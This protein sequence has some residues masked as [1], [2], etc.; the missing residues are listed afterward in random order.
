MVSLPGYQLTQTYT[1]DRTSLLARGVRLTD[2]TPV[3]IRLLTASPP[4]YLELAHL[5]RE[6]EIT[7]KLG[8]EGVLEPLELVR[9]EGCAALVTAD[10]SGEVCDLET[11]LPRFGMKRLITLAISVTDIL[12][13]LHHRGII[14]Q[15]IRPSSI[16]VDTERFEA[17]LTAFRVAACPDALLTEEDLTRFHEALPYLSPEQTGRASLQVTHYSD[18]YSLGMTLYALASGTPPFAYTDPLELVHAHMA[19]HPEPLDQ[20]TEGPALF[21]RIIDKLM[22]KI[23]EDRYHGGAG[24]RAD[25]ERCLAAGP[26]AGDT[27]LGHTDISQSFHI[28]EKLYGRDPETEILTSVWDRARHGGRCFLPVVGASGMGKS[29]LVESLRR[30]V[31]AVRGYFVR[32]NCDHRRGTIPYDALAGAMSDL[33]HQLMAESS[34]EIARRRAHLDLS[35]GDCGRVM[36]DMVPALRTILGDREEPPHLDPVEAE[37]RF[38]LIFRRFVSVFADREH[39]LVIYLT[40]LQWTGSST[41]ELLDDLLSDSAIDH[42]LIVGSMTEHPTDPSS[43]LATTMAHWAEVGIMPASLEVPAMDRLVIQELLLDALGMPPEDSKALA[44]LVLSRTG[45]VPFD[46]RMM[47]QSMADEEALIFDAKLGRWCWKP[48]RETGA[49]DDQPIRHL[50]NKILE[51]SQDARGVL[52]LASCIGN[53]FTL[54]MLSIALQRPRAETAERL[55]EAVDG[56]LVVPVGDAWRLLQVYDPAELEAVEQRGLEINYRFSHDRVHQ[57]VYE[58]MAPS[59]SREQHMTVGRRFLEHS[60][61]HALSDQIFSIVSQLNQGAELLESDEERAQL[62]ELNR[63]AGDKARNAAAFPDAAE[64]YRKGIALLPRESIGGHL[65]LS[66]HL[67]LAE[68]AILNGCEEEAG[69]QIE[70]LMAGTSRVEDKLRVYRQRVA[71]LHHAGRLREAVSRGLEALRLVDIRVPDTREAM[72]AEAERSRASLE[73][74]LGTDPGAALDATVKACEEGDRVLQSLLLELLPPV[75]NN[76]PELFRLLTSI[77]MDRVLARGRTTASPF[78]VALFGIVSVLDGNSV[79]GVALGELAERMSRSLPDAVIR[80]RL[81]FVTCNVLQPWLRDLEANIPVM[82]RVFTSADESG[83]LVYA[84]YAAVAMSHQQWAREKPL[85]EVLDQCEQNIDYLK[86]TRN[87]VMS[88]TLSHLSRAILNLRGLSLEA[89]SLDT[90]DFDTAALEERLR[91]AGYLT[92]LALCRTVR[93]QVLFLRG[94]TGTAHALAR[95]SLA[96]MAFTEGLPTRPLFSL[97]RAL[98]AAAVGGN[99]GLAICEEEE[100]RFAKWAADC[101]ES[102]SHRHALVRAEIARLQGRGFEAQRHYH[103]AV[104][105]AHQHAYPLTEAT[106]NM[107]ATKFFFERSFPE[108]GHTHLDGAFFCFERWGAVAVCRDL[109]HRYTVTANDILRDRYRRGEDSAAGLTNHYAQALDRSTLYKAAQALTGEIRL[110]SLLRKMMRFVSENAGAQRGLFLMDH[111]G[112]MTVEVEWRVFEEESIQSGPCAMSTRDD[113]AKPVVHYVHRTRADLLIDNVARDKR[114]LGDPYLSDSGVKTVLCVPIIRQ[115]EL[116]GI[117]YLENHLLPGAFTPDRLELLRMLAPQIAVSIENARFIESMATL[118]ATLEKEIAERKRA[119]NDLARA[120]QIAL[121]NARNVGKAEF[122]TSVLHNINNVLNS[123]SLACHEMQEIIEDSVTTKLTRASALMKEHEADL[124]SFLTEHERGKLI[125]GYLIGVSEILAQERDQMNG[126]LESMARNLG[127]MKGIIKTQQE[128]AKGALCSETLDPVVLFEEALALQ[129]NQI[130]RHGI[131]V[132]RRFDCNEPVSARRAELVHIL[133][134]LIK[135]AIEAMGMQDRR[136]LHLATDREGDKVA[137]HVTDSGVGIE[138]SEMDRL[139]THGFT[140]KDEGHG[141]GLAYCKREMEAMGGDITATSA[142]KGRGTTFS[143]ILPRTEPV[144]I[145]QTTDG[146][147]SEVQDTS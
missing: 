26:T 36:I 9:R 45:G 107:L 52:E 16:L 22:A 113:L 31:A 20:R 141:F 117:V 66:L 85:L 145:G 41:L 138:P 56:Q 89:A 17:R 82:R 133:L 10:F 1:Q 112:T 118:N 130:R 39:P 137:M 47:L 71:L 100:I 105:L 38:R 8:I 116:M 62:A 98:A 143:L 35:L 23:P 13:E 43:T 108:Y 104:R 106:A 95:E 135:N 139:F 34:E 54:R 119:E 69:T 60:R 40:N 4:S 140:T 124:N 126:E 125:P 142:G 136:E 110:D 58:M 128:S 115:T 131:S 146:S 21:F 19:R 72:A 53:Q 86:R 114:F 76:D 14:H 15:N 77:F 122:A 73:T 102:F 6:L 97:Y 94:E 44:D 28:P 50:T 88:D 51:L 87:A 46:V 48:A 129:T 7:T 83:D 132:T 67:G 65:W 134:N 30:P 147:I 42:L 3:L 84:A 99:E 144:S 64:Y 93:V 59:R 103:R 5:Q 11:F 123:V 55:A 121:A 32:G 25:L 70:L 75:Y 12:S 27:R 111:D 18:F 79:R 120:Q 61:A 91:R 63:T 109:R 74:R 57:A 68:A 127:L 29:S 78:A 101:P 33:V 96:L 90:P 81:R 24:L 80:N 92:G 49:G 2:R 37:A